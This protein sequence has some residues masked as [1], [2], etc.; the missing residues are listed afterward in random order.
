MPGVSPAQEQEAVVARYCRGS[1]T[2][3][4]VELW[5]GIPVEAPVIIQNKRLAAPFRIPGVRIVEIEDV[6]AK[7]SSGIAVG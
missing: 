1:D 4:R 5:V 7:L 6:R 3:K 2:V